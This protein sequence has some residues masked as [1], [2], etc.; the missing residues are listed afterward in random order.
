MS[1]YRAAAGVLTSLIVGLSACAASENFAPAPKPTA[2]FPNIPYAAWTNDEPDY[3][4]FPGDEIE[5]QVTAAPE[6]NKT[7]TVQPDGRVALPLITPVLVADRSVEDAEAALSQAY[8][9]QLWR[10]RVTISVR[11]QPLKVFVG[12]EVSKPG[13]YDMPGDINALQAVVLAGGFTNAAKMSEVVI[14]R[15]GPGGQPMMRTA[16]LL[17]GVSDPGQTDLVPMRRFD[18]VYVPKTRASEVDVFIQQYFRDALPGLDAS[19]SYATGG[20]KIF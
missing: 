8:A 16:D 4:L 10:P 20:A 14:I 7:V 13:I 17:H 5:V 6:L 3:R 18:I 19:F 1:S 9:S 15:R 11:P 2:E 12:G